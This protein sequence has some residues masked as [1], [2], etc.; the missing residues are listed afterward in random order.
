M[1]RT[2]Q[3]IIGRIAKLRGDWHDLV[4]LSPYAARMTK[5]GTLWQL[6]S[7]YWTLG[8]SEQAAIE[9]AADDLGGP[10]DEEG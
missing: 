5:N 8:Y 2:E 6:E 1:L 4:R 10:V 3:E 7:L 9:Q